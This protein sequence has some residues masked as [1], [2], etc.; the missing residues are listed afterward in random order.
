MASPTGRAPVTAAD[1]SYTHQLVAPFARTAYDSPEWG[2]RCYHLLH[3]DGLTINAGRQLYLN[4]RRRYAFFGVASRDTQVCVRANAAFAPGDDPNEATIG[5][6]TIEVIEPLKKI[7]IA[8]D[9]G[10]DAISAD[11]VFTARFPP[12]ATEPHV[13]RNAETV[14]T[15]YMNF[16]QSGT[17]DGTVTLDGRVHTVEH[18]A[19]FRDRG[20]GLR[21]HEG[22]PRRGLVAALFCELPDAALYLILYETAAGERVFTNGWWIDSG[23]ARD[24]VV[25]ADHQ[26]VLDATLVT[27]AR[28]E[29]EF[30]SGVRRHVDVEVITRNYLAGIGYSAEPR[31][32]TTG[33]ER[34]DLTDP[35]TVNLLDGQN[36]NGSVFLVDG[37]AGYGY[38]ETGIGTHA[39]YRP[40]D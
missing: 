33:I 38:L 27:G 30:E 37:V 31:F 7:R 39:R 13:V 19:G 40:S 21:K 18:R 12:V 26:L 4:D 3:V 22:S 9:A 20:W 5:P 17:Y 15:D 6:V 35:S 16:F 34:F 36:D 28:Y 14:V 1:E 23:G 11:L 24:T 25:A 29:I 8:V 2:D 32:K 10:S